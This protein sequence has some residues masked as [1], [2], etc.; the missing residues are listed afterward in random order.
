MDNGCFVWKMI[1]VCDGRIYSALGHV[2][3]ERIPFGEKIKNC[4]INFCE[5]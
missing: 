4:V 2:K 5:S 1:Y 3:I